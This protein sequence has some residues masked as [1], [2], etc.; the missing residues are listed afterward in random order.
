[1]TKNFGDNCFFLAVAVIFIFVFSSCGVKDNTKVEKS[2]I[3]IKD[4][5]EVEEP[6]GP[7][8][9]SLIF[10]GD[11]MMHTQQLERAKALGT[12]DNP[13]NFDDCFNL[14]SPVVKNADY[15]VVNLELALGGGND[16]SGFPRFSAPDSYAVALKDAGFDLFITANNHCLDRGHQGVRR[17]VHVLDS[18]NVDHI[19]TYA[20]FA[21]KAKQ[22]PFIKEINGIKIGFLNYT[23]ATNGIPAT[24]GVAVNYLNLDSIRADVASTRASGAEFI[25]VMPHWGNEYVMNES[26]NQRA[27]ADSLLHMGVDAIIGSHPHVVQPMNMVANNETGKDALIVYSLGNFISDMKIDNTRGGA[28]VRMVLARNE[29]NEVFIKRADYDTFVVEKPSDLNSNYRVIPSWAID[30]MA[31]SQHYKWTQ[32]DQSVQSLFKKR[33]VNLPRYNRES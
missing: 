24:D 17:T 10:F 33:E 7:D 13:Y 19:G 15:A 11:A 4:S 29:K 14:I 9:V 20:D 32:H 6:V 23:Y 5:P 27:L 25:I 3:E 21:T 1:M 16:Y 31:K 30:S 12:A 8:T 2:G 26:R 28:F 22:L 18:L